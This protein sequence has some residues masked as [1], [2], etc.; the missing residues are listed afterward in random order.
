MVEHSKSKSTQLPDHQ[1]HPVFSYSIPH[2]QYIQQNITNKGT[3]N[4]VQ[5]MT[6]ILSASLV[7]LPNAK[8]RTFP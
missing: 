1:S 2:Q 3:Y 8:D 5:S 7:V 6:Y 4:A